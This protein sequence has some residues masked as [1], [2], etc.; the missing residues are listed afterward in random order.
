MG[1][2]CEN[3]MMAYKFK[4]GD[5]VVTT[6]GVKGKIIDIC[7][8]QNCFDRGFFEPRWID[9]AGNEQYI[10]LYQALNGFPSYHKIG[11]YIFNDFDK[12]EVLAEM[13]SYERELKRLRKQLKVIEEYGG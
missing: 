11:D 10:D 7:D 13:A 3:E 1:I 6:E 4:P 12:G 9:E 5:E 8:C 2:K